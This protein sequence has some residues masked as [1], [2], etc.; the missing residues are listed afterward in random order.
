MNCGDG[1]DDNGTQRRIEEAIELADN[2]ILDIAR[3]REAEQEVLDLID[4]SPAG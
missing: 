4:D 3:S 2:G 1:A